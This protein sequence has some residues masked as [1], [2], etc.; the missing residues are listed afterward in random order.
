VVDWNGTPVTTS[1]M[2]IN[3]LQATVDA[4]K[5]TEENSPV[6]TVFNPT[7]G[8]GPSNQVSYSVTDAPLTATVL[9]ITGTE[10]A[11]FSLQ[12]ARF[13]DTNTKAPL[14]D[15][16]TGSG[17]VSIDWGDNTALTA[18]KV[19][20]PGGIGSQFIV[21]AGHTYAEEG[22]YTVKVTV[23]DLGSSTITVS[24]L[25]A[26]IADAA[27]SGTANFINVVRD[28]AFTGTVATFTDANSTAPLTD[29]TTAPGGVMIAW[30]DG[31]TSAGTVTQMGSQFLVSG[32][33]TFAT[34][35]GTL[36]MTVTITDLGGKIITAS[37][38]VQVV[39]RFDIVGRASETGQIYA[40]ISN[41]S[42]GFTTSVW[43]SWSTA[44]TWVDVQSGDFIGNGR[45]DLVGRVK[46][47]GDWWVAI[48]DGASFSNAPWGHWANGPGVTWVD[49]K[50]G[51]FLGNGRDDIMGR[52][53]ETGQ[54]W[55]AESTGSSFVNVPWTTWSTAV[56][57]T[58]VNVGDFNGDHMADITGRATVD[59]SWWTAIS[60]GTT[61]TTTQ[62]GSWSTLATWVD[63]KVGD[64]D[65]NGMTDIVGRWAQTGQWWVGQ[66]TGTSFTNAL[67]E[68]WNPG[69]T[70]V[71]V[72]VG[73]FNGD[74]KADIIGRWLEAGIWYVGQ[75]NGT[76]FTTTQWGSWSTKVNWVDVQVGDFNS[77]GK[78]DVIG[79]FPG[80]G[81]WWASISNGSALTNGLWATWPGNLTWVDVHADNY[82]L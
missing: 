2:G 7:P 45:A 17:G 5:V 51:D 47:S 16:T 38:G 81:Q 12:V 44:V 36:N 30:G 75:S 64:F 23:T 41:G 37:A 31:M 14:T 80:A 19:T 26:T 4:A 32:T 1:F 34:N 67:W 52:W 50:V 15:F 55:M 82:A 39:K 57:W 68:T 43:G 13:S 70:W 40:G 25:A 60:S 10:G 8:G 76:G 59:G 63:V 56:K 66:S 22:N 61:A 62:W 71:N 54:W 65:G 42:T 69:A 29:F 72:N 27:L 74:G 9:P 21:T 79:L 78:S 24:S 18:G 33:H 53:L 58:D 73:D 49:V 35:P 3:Q 20:Q 77:D 46:E 28:V 11:A 48:S 6:I